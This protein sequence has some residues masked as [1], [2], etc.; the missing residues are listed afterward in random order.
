MP[1][2]ENEYQQRI[3]HLEDRVRTLQT[4]LDSHEQT[5]GASNELYRNEINR[6][7][8]TVSSLEVFNHIEYSN[9]MRI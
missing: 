6:L 4:L 1:E 5:I 7:Q 8:D 9:E 2:L 3:V